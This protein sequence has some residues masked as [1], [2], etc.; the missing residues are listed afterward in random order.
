MCVCVVENI[1]EE[2]LEIVKLLC[3]IDG[4]DVVCLYIYIYIFI[5]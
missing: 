2:Y 3:A 4:I 1:Q 5:L